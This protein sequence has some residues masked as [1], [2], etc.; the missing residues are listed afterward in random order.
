MPGSLLM[1]TY[2]V[3]K[4]EKKTHNPFRPNQQTAK[5]FRNSQKSVFICRIVV[6]EPKRN[7]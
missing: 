1:G 3:K 7:E 6:N 4:I 5:K 2:F